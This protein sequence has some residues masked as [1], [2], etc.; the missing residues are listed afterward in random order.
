MMRRWSPKTAFMAKWNSFTC[1]MVRCSLTSCKKFGAPMD[2]KVSNFAEQAL[3]TSIMASL[4][5]INLANLASFSAFPSALNTK[6][7]KDYERTFLCF[8]NTSPFSHFY[9]LP[10]ISYF[11][12]LGQHAVSLTNPRR[13]QYW[14]LNCSTLSLVTQLEISR[15]IKDDK[16]VTR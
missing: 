5:S 6:K 2:F 14:F 3:R 12:R 15:K 9:S 10:K 8:E 11:Y 7:I 1:T 13:R 4:L 16:R